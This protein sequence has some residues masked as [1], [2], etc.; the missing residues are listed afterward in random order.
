MPWKDS[1]STGHMEYVS[2]LLECRPLSFQRPVAS[3][4]L[5]RVLL[6]GRPTV[7]PEP[8]GPPTMAEDPLATDDAFIPFSYGMPEMANTPGHALKRIPKHTP[9]PAAQPLALDEFVPFGE[10][11]PDQEADDEPQAAATAESAETAPELCWSPGSVY[12]GDSVLLALHED[13]IDFW[14]AFQPTREEAEARAELLERIRALV[15]DLW[16]GA[17]VKPFGSYAT[18]L[19]LPSS[20]VDIVVFGMGLETKPS[21]VAG[22][23]TCPNREAR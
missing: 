10:P 17:E 4:F 12:G 18:G 19:Y 5:P 1:T 13:V 16:P 6:A 11:E 9:T 8:E 23:E 22:L 21:R 15:N 3:V 7:L 14:Q 20:D 2:T